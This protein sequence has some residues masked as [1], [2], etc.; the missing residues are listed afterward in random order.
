MCNAARI[1]LNTIDLSFDDK[2]RDNPRSEN[3]DADIVHYLN[4]QGNGN[5]IAW[6]RAL[7]VT[8]QHAALLERIPAALRMWQ[9]SLDCFISTLSKTSVLASRMT[10]EKYGLQTLIDAAPKMIP[11]AL[12]DIA[13]LL[14]PLQAGI[15]ANADKQLGASAAIPYHLKN[16]IPNPYHSK[17]IGSAEIASVFATYASAGTSQKIGAA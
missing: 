9:Q 1:A 17:K 16:M 15:P 2:L 14:K 7:D 4:Y 8:Q 11:L 10:R 3:Y 13:G 12:K 6:F 5:S